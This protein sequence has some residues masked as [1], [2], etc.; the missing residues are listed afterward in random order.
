MLTDGRQYIFRASWLAI[1]PGIALLVLVLAINL[2]G[3]GL[4]NFLDPRAKRRQ[5]EIKPL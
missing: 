3:D 1:Y 4:S 2:L 5:A